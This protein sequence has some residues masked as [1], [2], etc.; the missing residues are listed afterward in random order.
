MVS[1]AAYVLMRIGQSTKGLKE[2]RDSGERVRGDERI[3]GGTEFVERVLKESEE[4]WEKRF[5]LKQ[6][7]VN[8]KRLLENVA[9]HFGVETEDLKSGSKVP[10]IAKARAVLCYMGVRKLGLTSA[11]IAKELGISPSAVS[12][13][14]ERGRQALRNEALEECLMESQ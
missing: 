1:A 11:S 3:L 8:L 5:L 12:K 4:Q 14:I 10:T 9:S 6:R 2:L 7:G 13:S